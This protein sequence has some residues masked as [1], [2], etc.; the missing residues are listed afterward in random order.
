MNTPSQCQHARKE[1]R[2]WVIS[3]GSEQ[4]KE[5]CLDCGARI[6]QPVKLRPD[7]PKADVGL[8]EAGQALDAAQWAEDRLAM[9]P[10]MTRTPSPAG[11]GDYDDFL[12]SPAWRELRRRVM[13][14]DDFRCQYCLRA[15]ADEVHHKT[16]A[17]G[18]LAPAFDLVSVCAEC[19]RK[20]HP[21]FDAVQVLSD[22]FTPRDKEI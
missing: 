20:L 15:D 6:G 8:Y 12:K 1:I 10:T 17:N 4:A 14:R 21:D 3:N 16:Y 11:D 18:W 19:H 5:Q 22:G 7:Y 13:A 9:F 2:R